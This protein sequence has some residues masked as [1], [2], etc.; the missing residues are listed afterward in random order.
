MKLLNSVYIK[1]T[2]WLLVFAFVFVYICS[3]YSYAVT[4]SQ[5]RQD[6]H[7]AGKIDIPMAFGKVIE[8][9]E[10]AK[11]ENPVILIQDLHANYE[12]Q[13]NILEILKH[14]DSEY[15]ISRIGVEGSFTRVDTTLVASI[16]KENIRTEIV[17]YFMDKGMI[18]GAEAYSIY[19]EVPVLEGMEDR[20]LYEKN[21][22]LLK[23]SLNHRPEFVSILE[24]IK[25]LLKIAEG[26]IC[27]SD[28]QKF[29]THYVLYR[30]KNM[31]PYAFHKYLGGWAKKAGINIEREVPEY[32]RFIS[33]NRK[34]NALDYNKIEKEYDKLLKSLDLKYDGES[35][36]MATFK[37]FAN[38]FRVP[39]EIRQQMQ[40]TVYTE[41]GYANFRNYIECME[42]S[43]RIN[44]Y[45]V[46]KEEDV[47]IKKVCDGLAKTEAEKNFV[48]VSDYVQLL[49][50]FML[51]QM[52]PNDL[53]KFYTDADQFVEKFNSLTEKCSDEL[54]AMDT[55]LVSLKP[56]MEEMG[57]FYNVAVERDKH[58]IKN[59]V[60]KETAIGTNNLV[61]IT[62]G[63][64]TYGIA[65]LLK[66]R[67]VSYVIV[68]PL[69]T[70]HNDEDRAR[71]YSFIR[72]G[73]L[74]TYEEVLSLTLAPKSFFLMEWWRKRAVASTIGSMLRKELASAGFSE[75]AYQSSGSKLKDFMREWAKGYVK[76]NADGQEFSFDL[77]NSTVF[78]DYRVYELDLKG[79]RVML[80]IDKKTHEP[81]VL[82]SPMAD[83]IRKEIE[84]DEIIDNMKK[85]QKHIDEKGKWLVP[86]NED[87]KLML[88]APKLKP[89]VQV[90]LP[91]VA[92][93]DSQLKLQKE[94][95]DWLRGLGTDYQALVTRAGE[96][97]V[98]HYKELVT[99]FDN[100]SAVPDKDKEDYTL[101]TGSYLELRILNNPDLKTA[102]FEAKPIDKGRVH[103]E[104]KVAPK[105][106]LD[107]VRNIIDTQAQTIPKA[108]EKEK[109]TEERKKELTGSFG[110]LSVGLTIAIVGLITLAAT[111]Y[112]FPGFYADESNSLTVGFSA[113]LG[114]LTAAALG[115]HQIMKVNLAI[116]S[117]YLSFKNRKEVTIAATH[118]EILLDEIKN[119]IAEIREDLKIEN[120]GESVT[121]ESV[122]DGT[123]LDEDLLDIGFTQIKAANL[124][125]FYIQ[126]ILDVLKD[127]EDKGIILR[128][129]GA[130][131]QE[132]DDLLETDLVNL[133]NDLDSN[134]PPYQYDD[135]LK[136]NM[137]G[138]TFDRLAETYILAK[139]A[140]KTM[141]PDMLN[142]PEI[143]YK[144][145]E[146]NLKRS[147][148]NDA[149][150][151]KLNDRDK[152]L[153]DDYKDGKPQYLPV[154]T[155]NALMV[156]W[157]AYEPAKDPDKEV[158]Q[159]L[160][161]RLGFEMVTLS[162]GAGMA[163]V[164]AGRII[165]TS[166]MPIGFFT[167]EDDIWLGNPEDM[168]NNFVTV[169][170][171]DDQYAVFTNNSP[172][173][174][175]LT[176][177]E[178]AQEL[179]VTIPY[180]EIKV[181]GFDKE[182]KEEE[183]E[184]K[185]KLATS[186]NFIVQGIRDRIVARS[187]GKLM[188]SELAKVGY[189][190]AGLKNTAGRLRDYF[191]EW[192]KGDVNISAGDEM[193]VLPLN[194]F[195]VA[196]DI[197]M[198]E[199]IIK[200]ERMYFVLESGKVALV[201]SDKLSGLKNIKTDL[202]ESVTALIANPVLVEDEPDTSASISEHIDEPYSYMDNFYRFINKADEISGF[203]KDAYRQDNN[204][205]NVLP[206]VA[207]KGE[208]ESAM[209]PMS[210]AVRKLPDGYGFLILELKQLYERTVTE[211]D[212]LFTEEPV[213]EEAAADIK[214]DEK[215]E[216]DTLKDILVS[217]LAGL[218]AA[219]VPMALLNIYSTK[220]LVEMS[221]YDQFMQVGVPVLIAFLF[222]GLVIFFIRTG[223][224]K[225]GEF[226][227][228]NM[229]NR[230]HD[231]L[232][233]AL[234]SLG[235][236]KSVPQDDEDEPDMPVPDD[237]VPV[238]PRN[239]E[240]LR[241]RF[242]EL[243][244]GIRDMGAELEN[245][246]AQI[247]VSDIEDNIEL[248]EILIKHELELM[249]PTFSG[250]ADFIEDLEKEG[251]ITG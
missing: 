62:G 181:E 151:E 43:K 218:V 120:F 207:L 215:E 197:V 12:T 148:L 57:A 158:R 193:E 141:D 238:I 119:E 146:E 118:V 92:D 236:E 178:M 206:A 7:Y 198:Y 59:F 201:I 67:Q 122:K 153:T 176:A 183:K 89:I 11:T 14:V 169:K 9:Y 36:V 216:P 142:E 72:G 50:K 168:K 74:L 99:V 63:F 47:I 85:L 35:T 15:G 95:Q 78:D 149:I 45:R 3:D 53:D 161:R 171:S 117:A 205:R 104:M 221:M 196:G 1:I 112:F 240:F 94:M 68:K 121:S 184:R 131:I 129:R 182:Q 33:L 188:R 195:T 160:V 228:K 233:D 174:R 6:I 24:R 250:I 56:Y 189:T 217:A 138:V 5:P 42:L 49:V 13:K 147:L 124:K 83:A 110:M 246:P 58:F 55:L 224:V 244:N 194:R 18:T 237:D 44:S 214:T 80:G 241:E 105:A 222:T 210:A 64:H 81:K 20:D 245:F 154:A 115:I 71:Y 69:V 73:E 137:A 37:K 107:E 190:E 226:F 88:V 70:S 208:I 212:E 125:E 202:L 52:S 157:N 84:R 186:S 19:K 247:A 32:S 223:Y 111:K 98:Y 249:N 4:Y 128:L 10:S 185:I 113:F 76:I 28:L 109:Q 82:G 235:S 155:K 175:I 30:Q 134:T 27:S 60:N 172:H 127:A 199:L 234:G 100:S 77:I 135:I 192:T 22:E 130:Y 251:V 170:V 163:A 213:V 165:L 61:M 173:I 229:L 143:D 16:P 75:Y 114:G 126:R 38:F 162:K 87:L 39:Q 243:I 179:D 167:P 26:R 136:S 159:E 177:E 242:V 29:R 152:N 144:M 231:L 133:I 86:V 140:L 116:V 21:S 227:M 132:L 139:A 209:E 17:D 46:I 102:L 180:D 204:I 66:E 232:V 230:E 211:L 145:N 106:R 54:E 25:Y 150:A 51:N 97:Y 41:D 166:K 48:Y 23:S 31:E 191:R 40:Q 239:I 101:G 103:L 248:H 108:V 8:H 34:Y 2:S 90:S 123:F 93:R 219:M 65:R 91:V 200:T 156:I 225:P 220:P 96:V 164:M 187:V 79:E 203:I